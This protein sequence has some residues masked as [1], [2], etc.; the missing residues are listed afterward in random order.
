MTKTQAVRAAGSPAN[1][2][3]IVG[4]TPTAVYSWPEQLPDARVQ[5]LRLL[6][7]EWFYRNLLSREVSTEERLAQ[8]GALA[9]EIRRL[10]TT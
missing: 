2:A 1:L 8:M 4:V 10:A 6:R 3:A 9:A 7:P 5:Q